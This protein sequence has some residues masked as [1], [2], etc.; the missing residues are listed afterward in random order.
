MF[1]EKSESN[2][3]SKK[4]SFVSEAFEYLEVFI[5]AACAVLVIFL[6]A[7][8]LCTVDG[9]SMNQTFNSGETLVISDIAYKPQGG[10]VVVFHETG[11]FYNQ[12][13]VKRVIATEGQWI[14]IIYNQDNTMSVYVSDDENI[15]E[16]DLLDEPY[17]YLQGGLQGNY[18]RLPTSAVQVP[19]GQV[20]VM[21]DNRY[22]SSDSRSDRIGF[23]DERQILGKVLLRVTP[24]S[25]FGAV[26]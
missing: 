6:A 17:A 26:N 8:R 20:F 7:F 4:Q 10:D 1:K 16:D 24:V 19:A 3:S 14:S 15:T 23:V 13:L 25:K 5:F 2:E 21:G 18:T 22:N 9:D 12:A 11:D